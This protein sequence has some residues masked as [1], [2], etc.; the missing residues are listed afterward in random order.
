MHRITTPRPY[1]AGTY[2]RS[3]VNPALVSAV[4]LLAVLLIATVAGMAVGLGNY[5]L[6]ALAFSALFG[7]VLLLVPLEWLLTAHVVITVIIAGCIVYFLRIQ[8][9]HWLPFGSALLV[10]VKVLLTYLTTRERRNQTD[11]LPFFVLA[12]IAYLVGIAIGIAANR[13]PLMQSIVG[14]KNLLPCWTVF[15]AI[16]FGFAPWAF[17]KRLWLWLLATPIINFPFVLYQHFIVAARRT[18]ATRFDAVVGTFGGNPEG[19]GHTATLMLYMIAALLTAVGFYRC[20]RISRL[21]ML[22]VIAIAFLTII[23]SENKA[24][25]VLLPAAFLIFDLDSHLRRP[26]RFV[27]VGLVVA[28]ALLTM[29]KAYT[30]LYY[31]T[32]I[33]GKETTERLEYFFDPSN[34]K[35]DTGEVG[36]GASLSLWWGDRLYGPVQRLFG[37][38]PGASRAESTIAMGEVAK[39]YS[40]WLINSTAIAQLLWDQGIFGCL[41]FLAMLV[42]AILFGVRRYRWTGEEEDRQLLRAATA[43]TAVL[44]PFSLHNAH[45]VGAGQDQYLLTLALGTVLAASRHLTRERGR[46][47]GRPRTALRV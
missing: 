16:A 5:A 2:Q 17:V 41:S 3:R 42:G 1:S 47:A 25:F 22:G 40:P 18:D 13:L 37:Y 6:D 19:G 9:G 21:Y 33:R 11:T 28:L 30:A 32:G 20:G 7:V 8:Q 23:L 44:I 27:I 45:L 36:R 39:R 35:R 43:I 38:G 12:L 31:D 24:A 26:V 29:Y 4:L 15:V 34:I 14:L 10:G 46:V